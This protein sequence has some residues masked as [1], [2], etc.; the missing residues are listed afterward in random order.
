M[1]ECMHIGSALW[2]RLARKTERCS[3]L[4]MCACMLPKVR[5]IDGRLF[6]YV[7]IY[8]YIYRYVCMYICTTNYAGW[9]MV[10]KHIDVDICSE[11]HALY[12][13][14]CLSMHLASQ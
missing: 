14:F 13:Q 5:S 3:Y 1:W 9:L 11:L 12:T 7:Y 2:G 4:H 6:E 8:I 10:C